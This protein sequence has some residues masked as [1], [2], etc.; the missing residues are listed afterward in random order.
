[1]SAKAGAAGSI[2]VGIIAIIAAIP[3]GGGSLS[4]LAT[5]QS[6]LTML[7]GA[8]MIGVGI[9][10]LIASPKGNSRGTAKSQDLEYA[11]AAD[12]VPLPVIFGE[13][14]VVGNFMNY[15][16]DHF[17][18]RRIDRGGGKGGDSGPVQTVGFDYYLTYEYGLCMGPIDEI[19]QVIS[20]PGELL[21][22]GE[23]PTTI[24]YSSSDVTKEVN[25]D[26]IDPLANNGAESGLV[27]VYRGTATQDRTIAGDPYQ[28]GNVIATG[29]VK[30]GYYYKIET[31]SVVDFTALGAAS[32]AV[33]TT[34]KATN[35]SGNVLTASDSVTE[36]MGLN[37]RGICWALFM[38]F[39][40]GRFPTPKSYHF[41]LRRFPTHSSGFE[42]LRPDGTTITG[43]TVRGS[44][45]D[46]KP[47]YNQANPAA[48]LYEVLT[49]KVWGRGLSQDLFHEASWISVAS[50]FASKHIGMSFTIDSADKIGS[51]IDWIRSHT[52]LLMVFD[53]DLLR[54]R[55]LLDLSDTHG[56]IQTLTPADYS[57]I[58]ATRP[59]WGSTVND[60]RIEFQNRNK[61]YKSDSVQ[62]RDV[63]NY[64]VTG[65]RAMERIS[66]N[67]FNDYNTV[68]RQGFRIL[69][70]KAYP[71]SGYELVMNR[72]HSQIQVGDVVRVLV[73]EFE[74]DGTIF[75]MV[76]KIEEPD[77]SSDDIRI[78]GIED[79]VL[80]S[81]QGTVS[82]TVPAS[83]PWES[84]E[85]VSEGDVGLWTGNPEESP[86]GNYPLEVFE[87]PPI[88]ANRLYGVSL[89][90][91]IGVLA[92]QPA[93][94]H[95]SIYTFVAGSSGGSYSLLSHIITGF[96]IAG[97]LTSSY[98]VNN[99][100]DRQTGFTFSLFD[101]VK[102]EAEMLSMFSQVDTPDQSLEDIVTL[103]GP[104][105]II[106]G[107]ILCIGKVDKLGTNSY[108]ARNIVRG[109]FGTNIAKRVS[110]TQIMFV[111]NISEVIVWFYDDAGNTVAGNGLNRD[112]YFKAAANSA[113]A[114]LSVNLNDGNP[115]QIY[116]YTK[117][118]LIDDQ[119]G[120]FLRESDCPLKLEFYSVEDAGST[121]TVRARV[122]RRAAGAET[123]GAF[124]TSELL[125]E[126]L[127]VGT[128]AFRIFV[129]DDDT[130]VAAAEWFQVLV[131]ESETFDGVNKLVV[132]ED[133]PKTFKLQPGPTAPTKTVTRILIATVETGSTFNG[134]ASVE[135]LIIKL[136]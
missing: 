60:I 122:R 50:Y 67:G 3:T 8:A 47:A 59:M 110:G 87:I 53:G 10:G 61:N 40:I 29:H 125:Y 28:F 20:S 106:Q 39:K 90:G 32:N 12:G 131:G 86:T 94:Y 26:S 92:Q 48:I 19:V 2:V 65:R 76:T 84:I 104:F 51:V 25:L 56:A 57:V 80:K 14:R 79:V 119:N 37:Y 15:T 112:V 85:D 13:Q 132:I 101:P 58:R 107:E 9:Y 133:I 134:L 68:R 71:L 6:G 69:R 74:T 11:S 18:N 73:G 17:R 129:R 109:R 96:A 27:R 128:L 33:G 21:M 52:K 43:F 4:A 49:N 63:G 124:I 103:T 78:L 54:L 24:V 30:A 36:Y 31:Q 100:T 83:A 35:T 89:R 46:T 42:M 105:C 95:R 99:W 135:D 91:L 111:Q 1:M 116:H 123:S 77:S 55:C 108:N 127:N 82:P 75:M 5:L 113:R 121:W 117:N 64:N 115:V 72:F 136:L 41:I 16:L 118:A 23:S 98:N 70:E 66:L 44:A 120:E 22:M 97:E 38:D 88:L 114:S 102:D 126:S 34:F 93:G 130:M 62:V 81:R 7:G 45:D